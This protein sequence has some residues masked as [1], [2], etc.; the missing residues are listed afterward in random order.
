LKDPVLTRFFGVV[1]WPRTWLGIVFHLL[2]FPLNAFSFGLI[3]QS[4]HLKAFFDGLIQMK[5]QGWT[6]ASS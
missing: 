4:Q 6:R 3:E 5:T 1:T 2:A